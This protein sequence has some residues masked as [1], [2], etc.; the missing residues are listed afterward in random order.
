[1][2]LLSGYQ[3]HGA[4]EFHRFRGRRLH[5]LAPML[6]WLLG[7]VYL[8][9][10]NIDFELSGRTTFENFRPNGSPFIRFTGR[11]TLVKEAR[12]WRII[13]VPD[14]T[15]TSTHVMFDGT[16]VYCLT[17]DM[18]PDLKIL[19]DH[20]ELRNRFRFSNEVAYATTAVISCGEYPSA[21]PGMP[22]LVWLAFL[23]APAL[24]GSPA[25]ELPPPCPGFLAETRGFKL[26]VEWPQPN[27]Q[28]PAGVKYIVSHK[29]W[30][31]AARDELA[32]SVKLPEGFTAGVYQ[33]TGWTNLDAEGVVARFPMQFRL[34]HY[35]PSADTGTSPLAERYICEVEAV[36]MGKHAVGP[37]VLTEDYV[38]VLDGRFHDATHSHLTVCYSITNHTWK[39]T[40]DA[41]VLQ[42]ADVYRKQYDRDRFW[43]L[44][45]SLA[46]LQEWL[47]SRRWIYTALCCLAL[48]LCLSVALMARW[49]HHRRQ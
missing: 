41:T 27:S 14:D 19:R 28:F 36:S 37:L 2:T 1:M 40:N 9:G 46:S 3:W 12:N 45:T 49:I 5:Y 31:A 47:S 23:S 17:R 18:T 42:A 48:L 11:F 35:Y 30:Q 13:H 4:S 33:V 24:R 32:P 44:K 15:V 6:C 34:D 29:L 8:S 16:D 38:D 22:S 43:P 10:Q 7:A 26:V 20:P 25:P 39:T 21:A